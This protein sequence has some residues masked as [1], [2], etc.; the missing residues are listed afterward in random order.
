MLSLSCCHYI[1]C[2][3]FSMSLPDS[4]LLT[5][6]CSGSPPPPG[7]SAGEYHGSDELSPAQLHPVSGVPS[8]RALAQ[9][10]HQD[11]K[12]QGQDQLC[13]AWRRRRK[14]NRLLCCSA[15]ACSAGCLLLGLSVFHRPYIYVYSNPCAYPLPFPHAV[16]R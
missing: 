13:H 11:P 10:R 5:C 14:T 4:N 1:F 3:A 7:P 9:L 2:S 16:R 6:G 8:F 15:A 12:G